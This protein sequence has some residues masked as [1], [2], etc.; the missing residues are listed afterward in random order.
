M[1][2][3]LNIASDGGG[4]KRSGK[5]L[6]IPMDDNYHDHG[7]EVV[8]SSSLRDFIRSP[9]LYHDRYIVCTLPQRQ[10]DVMLFGSATHAAVLQPEVFLERYYGD[11][12]N[13]RSPC[14][15]KLALENAGKTRLTQVTTR[16]RG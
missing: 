15:H 3:Q 11:P 10:S 6:I 12:Y 13:V 8:T 7:A 9:K 5:H 4:G 1:F 16:G 14:S 2:A